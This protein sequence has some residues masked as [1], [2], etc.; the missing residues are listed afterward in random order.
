MISPLTP[1]GGEGASHQTL[2]PNGGEGRMR[3][4]MVRGFSVK[5]VRSKASASST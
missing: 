5:G 4:A 3:G 2:S 1:S